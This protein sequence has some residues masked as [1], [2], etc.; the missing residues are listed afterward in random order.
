MKALRQALELQQECTEATDLK[1]KSGFIL[2]D[3]MGEYMLM[4][5]GD[6][7]S[8][9]NGVVVLNDVSA[10]LWKKLEHPVSRDDLLAALLDQ[11]EVDE[12]TAAKDLDL[13]LE[14]L[15]SLD[16]IED[17]FPMDANEGSGQ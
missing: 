2:R 14:K 3:I 7:I 9:Y 15:R 17:E 5:V 16:V 12:A 6:N 4:P 10:F 13:L 1:A 11:Y 8:R